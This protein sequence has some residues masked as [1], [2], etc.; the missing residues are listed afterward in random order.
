MTSAA[1][2]KRE[3]IATAMR[4]TFADLPGAWTVYASPRDIKSLPAAVLS[5]REPYREPITFLVDP[6]TGE[7]N[8]RM[9]LTV[10]MVIRRAAGNEA[11]DLFDE[12]CERVKAALRAVTYSC[13]WASLRLIG[14]VDVEDMPALGAAMDIEVV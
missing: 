2:T 7:V 3:A 9:S 14:P 4:T 8:E 5:P 6:S 13:I 11:L 1:I 10:N 12:A